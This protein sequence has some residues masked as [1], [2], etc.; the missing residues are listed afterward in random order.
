MT[1]W[2]NMAMGLGGSSILGAAIHGFIAPR[3][4]IWGPLISCGPR[5]DS[6]RIALAFDD[7][8]D[9]EATPL[10]LDALRQADAKAVFFVIGSNARK[11]PALLQRIA[12]EGHLIANHSYDH[13]NFGAVR[14]MKYWISQLQRTDDIVQEATGQ[15]T[16]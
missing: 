3:S 6:N 15:R 16:M 12:D 2:L 10:V 4:R 7:G 14:S 5:D 1:D 13:D 8:A 11:W 9:P